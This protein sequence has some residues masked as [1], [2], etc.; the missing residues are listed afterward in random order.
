M[1]S[2]WPGLYD[3]VD[4]LDLS[5]RRLLAARAEF[6]SWARSA[7][8][9]ALAALHAHAVLRAA[10][11]VERTGLEL[12]VEPRDPAGARY[13]P[14]VSLRLGSSRL[15]LY[16]VREPETAPCVHLGVQRGATSTRF[17][18]FTTL[19]GVLLVRS[20][21]ARFDV[22]A[23]PIAES[24]TPERT[25]LEALLLRAFAILIGSYRSTLA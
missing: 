9:G 22:L 25:S 21:E 19:P 1:P 2:T 5:R 15:D 8:A 7:E 20:S 3:E 11:L 24:G 12:S 4:R 18:V 13:A 14:P 17:P 23:L 10:E 6:E 16:S